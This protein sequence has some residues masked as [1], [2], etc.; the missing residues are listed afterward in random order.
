MSAAFDTVD[1][2]IL[3]ARLKSSIGIKGTVRNWFTLYLN[4]RSQR[5][6]LNGCIS[7][8][9]RLPHGVP[10]GSCLGPLL[11]TIYSSK[12]FEVIKNHLLEV[13]ACADDT[14]LYL[15]FSADLA[16]NQTDAVAAIERCILDIRTRMLT[17][18]LKLND[19]KTEFMLIG[20]KQQL[21]KVNIYS[22]TV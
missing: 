17:D 18:K 8:S 1:H 6:S 16:S 20:T 15:S 4:N 2:N 5:V 13:H 14:Q 12:L 3:L 21:S 22:L 11:F 9:F 7:D 10:Q 19:D